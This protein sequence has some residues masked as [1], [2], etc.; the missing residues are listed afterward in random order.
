[1]SVVLASPGVIPTSNVPVGFTQSWAG[2]DGS[3]WSLTSDSEDGIVLGAGV[4]GLHMPPVQRFVDESPAVAGSRWRASRALERG[5]FWPLWLL[6]DNGGQDWILR[7]RAFWRTMHPDYPGQWTVTQPTGEYRT[8]ACRWV[9]SPDQSD[10]DPALMGWALYGIE[11]VAEDPYWRGAPIS[12]N[13]VSGSGS[14]FFSTSGSVV[15]LSPG[16]LLNNATLTNPG[17]VDAWLTFT[18]TADA[19]GITSVDLGVDGRVVE[20]PIALTSGQSV[21]VD[22]SP[23]GRWARMGDG[24]DVTAQ[25][26]EV[27]FAPLPAGESVPLTLTMTGTGTVDVSF[28]P[29]YW[30]AW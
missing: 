5:V 14:A 23:S 24:T 17:D 29:R 18:A 27:D 12:A 25:L 3:A 16:N 30:R 6:H 10:I 28:T 8:L 20:V 13:F 26:G 4:R 19:G 21:T 9:D 15:T 11:M 7:D 2:W 1:M 22:T